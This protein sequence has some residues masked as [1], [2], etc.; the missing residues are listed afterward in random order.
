M[1]NFIS[2]TVYSVFTRLEESNLRSKRAEE[3]AQRMAESV[4]SLLDGSTVWD[5]HTAEEDS[6]GIFSG[7][8]A[9]PKNAQTT[10]KA[11]VPL[12][13]MIYNMISYINKSLESVKSEGYNNL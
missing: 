11:A 8:W 4:G 6:V 7:D 3:N 9:R 12:R 1:N 10:T 5:N 13:L 2:F